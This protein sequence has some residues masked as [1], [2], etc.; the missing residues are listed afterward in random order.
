M[1]S[2]LEGLNLVFSKFIE[3]PFKLITFLGRI[4]IFDKKQ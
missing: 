4:K 2:S 1:T 3:F